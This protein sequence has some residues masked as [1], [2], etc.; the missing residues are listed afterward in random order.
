MTESTIKAESPEISN[1]EQT[2]DGNKY[3]ELIKLKELMDKGI[4]TQDDYD[5]KKKY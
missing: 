2:D 5:A 1:D 4:I 3:N